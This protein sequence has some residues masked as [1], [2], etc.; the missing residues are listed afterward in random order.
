MRKGDGDE[1]INGD[2][3]NAKRQHAVIV[4]IA[5]T[6][7]ILALTGFTH[8]WLYA[9]RDDHRPLGSHVSRGTVIIAS[10]MEGKY[11]YSVAQVVKASVGTPSKELRLVV[12]F[13]THLTHLPFGFHRT[14]T[15]YAHSDQY[16]NN[17][18]NSSI[19]SG[20][21]GRIYTSARG[22]DLLR[23]AGTVVRVPVVERIA[24]GDAFFDDA[25]CPDCDG[26]LGMGSGSPLWLRWSAAAI[27]PGPIFLDPDP[28]NDTG[29]ARRERSFVPCVEDAAL[30]IPSNDEGDFNDPV[31]AVRGRVFGKE[32]I[33]DLSMWS[34]MTVVPREVYWKYAGSRTISGSTHYP[35]GS[36]HLGGKQPAASSS[37]PEPRARKY[38]APSYMRMSERD[39]WDALEIE[40][41]DDRRGGP[42]TIRA[43]DIVVD[44]GLGG[45]MLLMTPDDGPATGHGR[46]IRL[47]RSAMYSLAV[48][49][50]PGSMRAL[51]YYW[52]VRKAYAPVSL[53]LM[54]LLEVLTVRWML[55]PRGLRGPIAPTTSRSPL[56]ATSSVIY[57]PLNATQAAIRNRFGWLARPLMR[58]ADRPGPQTSNNSH[59][60]RP[61]PTTDIQQQQNHS[62]DED[63]ARW[64]IELD[65]R[66][67]RAFIVKS[68]IEVLTIVIAMWVYF[69]GDTRKALGAFPGFDAF[70][71]LLTVGSSLVEAFALACVICKKVH[72][73]T[74]RV[75]WVAPPTTCS[76]NA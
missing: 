46:I 13:A 67:K 75:P 6:V 18:I 49:V 30:S 71:L 39:E 17:H 5:T 73:F 15:S 2:D 25:N 54:L 74:G 33:I 60:G 50:R 52:D 41:V 51:V 47:G 23:V 10:R 34:P 16:T 45:R 1:F 68:I 36:S 28:P 42:V 24:E 4:I 62:H 48:E 26:I 37:P 32:Y 69:M 64:C 43:E 7:L 57:A 9:L 66:A 59:I 53:L 31:C 63:G 14:S 38:Q 65:A 76:W 20:K 12:S 11:K 61:V 22:S 8:A 58:G 35:W 19:S 44:T 72:C 40:L 55:T 56:L 29:G 27:G 21:N 3:D 70:L